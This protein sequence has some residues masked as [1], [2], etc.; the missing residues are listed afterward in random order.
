MPPP[1]KKA[2]LDAGSSDSS[3]GDD[4]PAK[5]SCPY[6]AS[7]YRKNP[8]HFK[9]FSHPGDKDYT[10]TKTSTITSVS[11]TATIKDGDSSGTKSGSSS[12]PA[13]KYGA[14]CYRKNLMHF[15]EY[16]HPTVGSVSTC[17]KPDSGSDTDVIESDDDQ[18]TKVRIQ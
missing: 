9:E 5:K 7:C 1:A 15:A 4:Q 12:L 14:K 16:S 11:S 18:P 13:C 10:D 6:G 3:D 8:V 17:V 2:K